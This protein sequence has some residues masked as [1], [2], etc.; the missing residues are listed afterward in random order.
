MKD[1]FY[2]AYITQKN[3]AYTYIYIYIYI[4]IYTHEYIGLSNITDDIIKTYSYLPDKHVFTQG[5]EELT[6]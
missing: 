2:H 6:N 5:F 1:P 4:Y 3:A